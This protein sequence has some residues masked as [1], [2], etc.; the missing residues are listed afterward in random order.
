MDGKWGLVQCNSQKLVCPF[1]SQVITAWLS[2]PRIG[3]LTYFPPPTLTIDTRMLIFLRVVGRGSCFYHQI[4]TS[5]KPL[6]SIDL[7]NLPWLRLLLQMLTSPGWLKHLK[8]NC[9]LTCLLSA[10]RVCTVSPGDASSDLS[11]YPF[12]SLKQQ[13]ITLPILEA[14]VCVCVTFLFPTFFIQIYLAAPTQKLAVSS[15][16]FVCHSNVPVLV[17]LHCRNTCFSK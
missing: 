17:P 7:V 15:W 2:F 6:S 12:C 13:N 5:S 14:I 4:H 10:N 8:V 1:S 3:S 11:S 16:A 9:V